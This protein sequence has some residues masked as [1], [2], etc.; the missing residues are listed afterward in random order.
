VRELL[1][2]VI[3]LTLRAR[4]ACIQARGKGKGKGKGI[5]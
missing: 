3:A 5:L 1:R 2:N 4:F